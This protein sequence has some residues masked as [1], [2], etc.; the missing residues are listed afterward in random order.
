MSE[1]RYREAERKLDKF[2]ARNQLRRTPER[3]IILRHACDLGNPFTA[4]Q[5]MQLAQQDHI[6]QGTV[7]NTL[8]LL[9]SAQILWCLGKR[10]TKAEYEVVTGG[11][12]RMQLRCSEC[13]RV[14]DFKDVAIENLVNARKYSNFNISHFSLYV[15]GSCKTC[16]RKKLRQ[17]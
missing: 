5:L 17:K 12:I 16:R 13:G 9:V 8:S 2:I 7:Y 1:T 4:G 10:G 6:S 11:K 3:F 14:A 15:Y